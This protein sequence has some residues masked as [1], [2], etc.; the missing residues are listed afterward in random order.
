MFILGD[1]HDKMG[2]RNLFLIQVCKTTVLET[3][4]QVAPECTVL[5]HNSKQYKWPRS[6]FRNWTND[7]KLLLLNVAEL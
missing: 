7:N 4:Q 3:V 2:F 6:S 5:N 1:S